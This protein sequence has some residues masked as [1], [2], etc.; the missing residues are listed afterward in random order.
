[1]F[2]SEISFP[3]NDPAGLQLAVMPWQLLF[4][5]VPKPSQ[6]HASTLK[7]LPPALNAQKKRTT[8]SFFDAR[9]EPPPPFLLPNRV[10]LCSRAFEIS[11]RAIDVSGIVEIGFFLQSCCN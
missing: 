11:P 9:I 3:P 1:M 6:S 8:G 10:L 7:Q 2:F 4:R 5:C